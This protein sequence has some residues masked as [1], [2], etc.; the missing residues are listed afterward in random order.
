M[1]RRSLLADLVDLNDQL[2]TDQDMEEHIKRRRD[3]EIGRELSHLRGNPCAQVR[4]WLGRV[5]GHADESAGNHVASAVRGITFFITTLGALLGWSCALA[6]FFYDGHYP[7]NVFNVLAV[8]V[9]LQ[10]LF[11]ALFCVAASPHPIPGLHNIQSTLLALSPGHLQS[12]AA[13]L[14]PGK[15]RDALSSWN[16]PDGRRHPTYA[17][18]RKWMILLW[19]QDLALAFNL[20]AVATALYLVV[21]SDL[22]FGWST[23][24]QTEPGNFHALTSLLA[25]PWSRWLPDAVPSLSLVETTRFFRLESGT[26]PNAT[27]EVRVDVLGGWWPFLLAS[28]VCYGL[29]PRLMSWA[30]A[31][32]VFK[33]T[34]RD[35]L[36]HAPGV[37]QLLD[38][39]NQEFVETIGDKPEWTAEAV[40]PPHQLTRWTPKNDHAMVVNWSGVPVD[41]IATLFSHQLKLHVEEWLHAGGKQT[42]KQDAHT[43]ERIV[44][45]NSELELLVVVK[46][47]E[48]PLLEFL[49]FISDLRRA[50]G[51]D[52]QILIVPVSISESGQALVAGVADVASWESKVQAL[53]DPLI[54]L[55]SHQTQEQ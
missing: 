27:A 17:S 38:S 18:I 43:I 24:L 7:V 52:R 31:F 44:N 32:R 19:S 53:G 36:T 55:V 40:P 46:A 45:A 16:E 22:A 39:M 30:L 54:K 50:V 1:T 26:F 23:T 28:M 11:V 3:R 15:Y 5:R 14:L 48:P 41:A 21:F 12:V 49:D 20:S 9:A 4:E 25:E 47:W 42:L 33:L 37:S 34:T 35:A 13:R 29:L 8:F 10:L 2:Q 51:E 6:V